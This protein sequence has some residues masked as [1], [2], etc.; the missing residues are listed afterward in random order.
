MNARW[1]QSNKQ[2]RGE[3]ESERDKK[4][5]RGLRKG[6]ISIWSNGEGNSVQEKGKK[7]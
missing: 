5:K 1:G 3:G 7:K 2:R 4:T 6:F